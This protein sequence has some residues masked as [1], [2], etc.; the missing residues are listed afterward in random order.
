MEL[1]EDIPVPLT[2]EDKIKVYRKTKWLM[3]LTVVILAVLIS[4]ILG[5]TLLV[6]FVPV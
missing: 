1:Q 2:E 3:F 5:M 4:L 6:F